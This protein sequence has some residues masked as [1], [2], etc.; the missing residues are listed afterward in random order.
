MSGFS[1]QR[2]E[3]VASLQSY[4]SMLKAKNDALEQLSRTS[5]EMRS[6]LESDVT[7]DISGIIERREQDCN[8]FANVCKNTIS[9]D[10]PIID[11]ARRLA[12]STSD[13]LGKMASLILSMQEDARML[14][15]EILTCQSECES[16][17]KQRI[18]ATGQALRQSTRRRKLDSAYGPAI[19]HDTP[20]FLD[21]QQ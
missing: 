12:G 4:K 5:V 10:T 20:A 3:M 18:E 19:R 17:L 11:I 15:A 1:S 6:T 13:D 8:H 2:D 14:S 16:I 9:N 21:K 7:V